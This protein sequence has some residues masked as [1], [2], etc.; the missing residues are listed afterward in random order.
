MRIVTCG[1]KPTTEF[2]T[3]ASLSKRVSQAATST[4]GRYGLVT[5]S[6]ACA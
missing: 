5:N 6:K 2:F 1:F 4:T 3:R